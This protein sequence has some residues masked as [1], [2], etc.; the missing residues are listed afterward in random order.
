MVRS[1]IILKLKK[2]SPDSGIVFKGASDTEVVLKAYIQW[3]VDC[4]DKFIGMFAFAIWDKANQKLFIARDRLG[5]KPLYYYFLTNTLLFGSELKALM[6][7]SRFPTRCRSGS[8]PI[9]SSLSVCAGSQ[10]HF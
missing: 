9:V 7:F 6:A 1:I 8:V 5:I 10:N 4:L 2:N 3:G